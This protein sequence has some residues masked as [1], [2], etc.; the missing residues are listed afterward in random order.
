MDDQYESQHYWETAAD[1]VHVFENKEVLTHTAY[2]KDSIC[3]KIY[4]KTLKKCQVAM[5]RVSILFYRSYTNFL[6]PRLA[7]AYS[8]HFN[9]A[10]ASLM[11]AF[12]IL[13]IYL[14][15]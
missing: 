14:S 12:H 3:R 10:I 11:L 1:V 9:L 2:L 13:L 5:L 8:L 4:M 15:L 6:A 7:S